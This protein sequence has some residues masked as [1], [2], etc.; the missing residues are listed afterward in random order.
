MSQAITGSHRHWAWNIIFVTASNNAILAGSFQPTPPSLQFLTWHM[1]FGDIT[2]SF[3]L[4]SYLD[5]IDLSSPSPPSK[6]IGLWVRSELGRVCLQDDFSLLPCIYM[7]SQEQN[8]GQM[9]AFSR[10]ATP[11]PTG[12][13]GIG[14]YDQ[15]DEE[16]KLYLTIV[17]HDHGIC[18]DAGNANIYAHI[19]NDLNKDIH[20]F[21]MGTCVITKLNT[22]W[23]PK[24]MFSGPGIEVAHIIPKSM[25][26]F[27]PG[28]AD[29][30]EAWYSTNS[31][32]NCILLESLTHVVHDNRLIAIEP[33]SE[34]IR[35]FAPIKHL[36]GRSNQRANFVGV[37]PTQESMKWHYEMCVVENMCALLLQQEGGAK[38]SL[39]RELAV[40]EI[41]ESSEDR[42][43]ESLEGGEGNGGANEG[44]GGQSEPW[45]LSNEG[46]SN[47][48]THAAV[49]GMH[50]HSSYDYSSCEAS[51][52]V[53]FPRRDSIT[54]NDFPPSTPPELLGFGE[55]LQKPKRKIKAELDS[56]INSA[57]IASPQNSHIRPRLRVYTGNSTTTPMDN[58]LLNEQY[59]SDDY[60][61]GLTEETELDDYVE[62]DIMFMNEDENEIT[63][64]GRKLWEGVMEWAYTKGQVKWKKEGLGG[65]DGVGLHERVGEVEEGR[66]GR[67]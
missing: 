66:F 29:E 30:E 52:S 34:R 7:N 23:G 56:P 45:P 10:P 14:E 28:A 35:L 57:T 11:P 62:Q 20:S 37:R 46:G 19:R 48:S 15:G 55:K 3:N 21:Y 4:Q 17:L 47:P 39:K 5:M 53:L 43:K 12:G 13:S 25:Y 24:N 67:V 49:V 33:Q 65:C 22:S 40:L 16:V 18:A 51:S 42:S 8:L 54:T 36:L 9:V 61:N 26:R 63:R 50:N 41:G 2:L 58:L 31:Y 6:D 38:R 32:Q 60:N 44:G 1:L 59:D 64:Q 27:Y